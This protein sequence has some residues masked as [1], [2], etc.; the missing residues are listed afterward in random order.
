MEL[1]HSREFQFP[2]PTHL[3]LESHL[4]ESG[5]FSLDRAIFGGSR[6][7]EIFQSCMPSPIPPRKTQRMGR[8]A[9]CPAVLAEP[10]RA[11]GPA[12]RWQWHCLAKLRV[13]PALLCWSPV[14]LHGL[15]LA[16]SDQQQHGA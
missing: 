8:V 9:P 7:S 3:R 15:V 6:D 4:G 1:S 11:L 10:G 5:N 14:P 12:G 2:V 16:L 13:P